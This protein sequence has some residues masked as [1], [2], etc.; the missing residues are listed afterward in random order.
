MHGLANF[1]FTNLRYVKF[2]QSADVS[3]K[4]EKFR[5]KKNEEKN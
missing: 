2:Q 3:I 1:K 4:T 5:T